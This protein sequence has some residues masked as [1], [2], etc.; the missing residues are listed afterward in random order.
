MVSC[1]NLAWINSCHHSFWERLLLYC[2]FKFAKSEQEISGSVNPHCTAS[3]FLHSCTI[4]RMVGICCRRLSAKAFLSPPQFW[5]VSKIIRNSE[6]HLGGMI[7]YDNHSYTFI[8][9]ILLKSL[10]GFFM[11]VTLDWRIVGTWKN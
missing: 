5:H 2:S 6:P 11:F 9:L 10:C 4:Q 7:C 8:T 3:L 1:D